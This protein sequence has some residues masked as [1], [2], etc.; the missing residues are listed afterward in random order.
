M[1]L[2][3]LIKSTTNDKKNIIILSVYFQVNIQSLL[4]YSGIYPTNTHS[5]FN[6]CVV[7]MIEQKYKQILSKL[8]KYENHEF[9]TDFCI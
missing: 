4:D 6:P 1:Y 7:K 9:I 3:I 2:N 8:T 5:L